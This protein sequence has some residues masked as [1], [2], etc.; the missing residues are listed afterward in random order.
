MEKSYT[1]TPAM[2][3]D[4]YRKSIL[5]EQCAPLDYVM[6]RCLEAAEEVGISVHDIYKVT[7]KIKAQALHHSV[8]K[9]ERGDI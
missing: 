8:I 5:K 2:D 9:I 3:E 4:E 7:E 1:K 6:W